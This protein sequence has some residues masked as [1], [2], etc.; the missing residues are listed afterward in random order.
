MVE[1]TSFHSLM[2]SALLWKWDDFYTAFEDI[3]SLYSDKPDSCYHLLTKMLYC[4]T[5]TSMRLCDISVFSERTLD[6]TVTLLSVF[7]VSVFFVKKREL[8]FVI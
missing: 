7:I 4:V 1:K 5:L 6:M 3:F 8:I 2:L